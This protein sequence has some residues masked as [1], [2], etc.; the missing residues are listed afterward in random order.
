MVL[1]RLIPRRIR[2][3]FL[4]NLLTSDNLCLKQNFPEFSRCIILLFTDWEYENQGYYKLCRKEDIRGEVTSVRDIKTQL[5]ASENQGK[6][7]RHIRD[8]RVPAVVVH[9]RYSKELP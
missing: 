5:Q 2:T 4:K 8:N 9:P 1:Q 3:F 6:N 7:E